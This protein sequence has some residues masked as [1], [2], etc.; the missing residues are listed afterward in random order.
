MT[1][2]EILS[3]V[4]HE[5]GH[6]KKKHIIK[7]IILFE[8]ISLFFFYIQNTLPLDFLKGMLNSYYLEF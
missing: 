5:S 7:N 2:D 3:V 6:W 8:V 1:N 4:A